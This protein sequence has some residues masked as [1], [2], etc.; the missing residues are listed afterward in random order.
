MSISPSELKNKESQYLLAVEKYY[1]GE[2]IME[3]WEFDELEDELKD[4]GSTVINRVGTAKKKKVVASLFDDLEIKKKKIPHKTRMLSLAKITTKDNIIPID[5]ALKWF[6]KVNVSIIETS[7]KYDGN[8]ASVSYIDGYLEHA[9]TRG[10]EGIEGSDITDKLI[11]Q[12]PDFLVHCNHSII[13]IRGEVLIPTSVF[14]NKY[15]QFK[16]PRNFVAGI[17]NKDNPDPEVL[18]DLHF[19]PYEIRYVSSDGNWTYEQAVST[20]LKKNN[21]KFLP[22]TMLIR[23]TSDAFEQVYK[24]WEEY[25][26]NKSPYL[27]DGFVLKV[28]DVQRRSEL[29]ENNHDP[30]WALACKFSPK[31]T[32]TT[33]TGIKWK[34]GKTG[35]LSPVG[36]LT[37]VDLDGSTVSQATLHNVK[38]ITENK[39]Y[40][41]AV[42]RIHK[43][44]DI[45]PQIHSIITPSNIDYNMPE[46]CPHCNTKLNVIDKIHLMCENENCSGKKLERFIYGVNALKLDFF[47]EAT[48]EKIFNAGIE[49]P[50]D[51]FD[52]TKFNRERLI[53]FGFSDGISLDKLLH[54]V[55]KI[56]SITVEQTLLMLAITGLG[57]SVSKELAKKLCKLPYSDH[58]LTKKFFTMFDDPNDPEVQI[59][60]NGMKTLINNGINVVKP[61]ISA[62]KL[63]FEMTG[64]PAKFGF[65]T[66]ELF[67][68]FANKCGYQQSSLN[69]KTNLLITDDIHSTTSKMTKAKDLGVRIISYDKFIEEYGN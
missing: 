46:F 2:P 19:I 42:V 1:S 17:L 41:G 20:F 55:N 5:G 23:P 44:G 50:F 56:R 62:D 10:D 9:L 13:E 4:L 27:L 48:I 64:S 51:L 49:T 53:H 21:F 11:Q 25:R 60:I 34:M 29:G 18:K 58:G 38:Y 54:Q 59:F 31:F 7:P 69:Q 40:P 6:K 45:I 22:E 68:E 3:D 16:N 67:I 8:S 52:P 15:S 30:E 28:L 35:E 57:K 66:K 47:G 37:P 61:T 12:L 39:V 33:I 24:Y 65:K 26:E 63:T 14:D 36:I 43:G 32:S